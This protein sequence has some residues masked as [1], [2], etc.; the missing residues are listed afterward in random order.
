MG[1]NV[2]DWCTNHMALRCGTPH[3][4]TPQCSAMSRMYKLWS[5]RSVSMS[6]YLTLWALHVPCSTWYMCVVS[7]TDKPRSGNSSVSEPHT[8][9]TNVSEPLSGNVN[10]GE[11]HS[12][13]VNVSEPTVECCVTVCVKCG[14]CTGCKVWVMYWV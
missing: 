8:Q 11:P 13:N 4:G 2:C 7:Y 14:L 12:G 1:S 3:S 5:V 6:M 9:N 10:V